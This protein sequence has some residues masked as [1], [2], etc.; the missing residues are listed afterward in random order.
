MKFVET[1]FSGFYVDIEYCVLIICLFDLVFS[2][3]L[4][5]CDWLRN[6]KQVL[7]GYCLID[8][9]PTFPSI[10]IFIYRTHFDRMTH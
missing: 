7:I 5:D 2:Y 10:H 4:M 9:Y 6:R 8:I 1:I 3:V